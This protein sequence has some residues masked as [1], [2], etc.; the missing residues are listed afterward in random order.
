MGLFFGEKKGPRC[1]FPSPFQALAVVQRGRGAVFRAGRALQGRLCFTSGG[2]SQA[3][4]LPSPQHGPR[5]PQEGLEQNSRSVF[6]AVRFGPGP[7]CRLAAAQRKRI[8]LDIVSKPHHQECCSLS[9]GTFLP[10]N[11]TLLISICLPPSCSP[12]LLLLPAPRVPELPL[13]P[14]FS[15]GFSGAM[16]GGDLNTTNGACPS[17]VGKCGAAPWALFAAPCLSFPINPTGTGVSLPIQSS[18]GRMEKRRGGFGGSRSHWQ[19]GFAH[20]ALS[21]RISSR[22]FGTDPGVLGSLWGS[23][24]LGLPQSTGLVLGSHMAGIWAARHFAP[25]AKT[26]SSPDPG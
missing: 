16:L 3:W 9:P 10:G 22:R 2:V 8:C 24:V 23:S 1:A 20:A 14:P 4:G 6:R 15:D 25:R 11:A 5:V 26:R 19:K 13:T 17:P 21:R 12:L 18:R 7:P